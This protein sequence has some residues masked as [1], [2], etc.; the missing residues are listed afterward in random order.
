MSKRLTITL[1]DEEYAYLEQR[2]QADRRTV[3]DMAARLVTAPQLTADWTY[4]PPTYPQ[5]WPL[6]ITSGS[7]VVPSCRACSH[8]DTSAAHTCIK[9]T[10]TLTNT[11]DAR[12]LS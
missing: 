2:A 12:S 1:T 6:A 9:S 4:R 10:W 3:R 5:L 7:T 8:P 11:C